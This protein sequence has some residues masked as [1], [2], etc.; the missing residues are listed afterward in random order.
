MNRIDDDR[1]A[2]Y[3]KH[4]QRIDEWAAL[5]TDALALTHRFLCSCE[6]DVTAM[7]E[8]LGHDVRPFI[9]LEEKFP[10]LFLHRSS[11]LPAADS[12]EPPRVAIGIE[13]I[14]ATVSFAVREKTAYAGVWVRQEIS[15]GPELHARLSEAFREAGLT[16]Q[17]RLEWS[18]T[19]WPAYRW[20]PA[21]GDFWDD[22]RPYRTQLVESVRFFWETFEPTISTIVDRE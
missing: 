12:S 7:A 15:G 4:Q 9:S 2:F 5:A 6:G 8:Q 3:L 17:S 19:W 13:W 11:W 14:P 22:L 21:R 18:K 16:G 10:K 20:E 1:V